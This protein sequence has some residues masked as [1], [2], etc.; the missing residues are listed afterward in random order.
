MRA[1]CLPGLT[2]SAWPC[3]PSLLLAPVADLRLL[4]PA[5]CGSVVAHLRDWPMSVCCC[6]P[7]PS[8]PCRRTTTEPLPAGPRLPFP[9]APVRVPSASEPRKHSS[10]QSPLLKCFSV[11]QLPEL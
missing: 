1:L 11:K 8:S 4:L 10:Y 5:E 6:W 2:A 7:R 3:P 9:S